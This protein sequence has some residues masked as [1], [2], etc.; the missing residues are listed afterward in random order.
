MYGVIEKIGELWT[1]HI[2]KLRSEYS[3]N[4]NRISLLS[5]HVATFPCM[6]VYTRIVPIIRPPASSG[7]D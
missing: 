6:T 1:P 4:Q 2:L 7:G 3:C 5:V